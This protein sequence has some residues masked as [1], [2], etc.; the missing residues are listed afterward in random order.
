[1]AWHTFRNLEKDFIELTR[2][3]ALDRKNSGVWSERIA[4]LLL[5]T[6]S[7]VD[8]V[9]SEMRHCALLPRSKALADLQDNSLPNIGNYRDVYEPVYQLSGVEVY[10]RYGLTD[11]GAVRPFHPFVPQ[12]NPQWW[13]AYNDIKHGFFQD[14]TKGTL[15]N[16]VHALGALFT[17][18]VLH[19]DSQ[20]YLLKTDIIQEGD[21]GGDLR[22]R[23][24]FVTRW[25]YFK[26]SFIGQPS[27]IS[28]DAW[29]SSEIFLHR[30]RKDPS[31]RA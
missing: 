9:F 4:Q 30:F 11:Y 25:D 14:M 19:K 13:N 6:G 31:T 22:L 7:T 1:M 21:F 16:L 29:A 23:E 2:Y 3:V 10:A 18:N 28:W 24:H 5:V 27:N 12:N 26:N 17:L 20:R 8:S 15:D